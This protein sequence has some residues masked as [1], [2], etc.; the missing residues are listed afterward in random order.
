MIPSQLPKWFARGFEWF[1]K[2][3]LFDELQGDLEEAFQEN[4]KTYGAAKARNIYRLE[5]LKM[6][7]PS[8]VGFG[9]FHSKFN[10]LIMFKNYF[11]T[12]M[13]SMMKSPLSS[14]INIFGLSVA[15]GI[16]LI[17][18]AF[19]DQDISIDQF[20]E[21]KHQVYLVTAFADRDGEVLQYGQSPLP[22]ATHMISDLPQIKKSS[23]VQDINT[24]VKYE[25]RVFHERIRL[26]DPDFLDMLTFPMQWGSPETLNDP[27]SI[28]LSND[29]AIKY[30]G[31]LNPVG[32][33]LLINFGNDKTKSFAISGV[34][35]PFPNAHAIDFDFLINF[36]NIEQATEN[37]DEDNWDQLIAATLIQINQVADLD[38]V[39][40]QL[41]RYRKLQNESNPKKIIKSVSLV[42][43]ADLHMVS[44][45]IQNGISY[46]VRKEGWV[47][48]SIMAGFVMLL[49][50]MNYINIGIVSAAKRLKEI[51][52]RKVIGANRRLVLVQLLTENVLLTS[53][54]LLFG[55]FLAYSL[56]IPW[57]NSL[58]GRGLELVLTQPML[59]LFLG[60]MLLITGLGSGIY[61]ALYISKF[62]V[63]GIFRGSIQLGK[64]SLMTKVFLTFQ[65]VLA[66]I[67]IS[68]GV[69][70]TQNNA[71]QA[72][73]SW[74][75]SAD[76][77][78]YVDVPDRSAFEQMH[79]AM[80]QNP[81]VISISG[82]SQHMGHRVPQITI[83]RP[84][85][86]FT[87]GMMRVGSNYFRTMGI[88]LI[89]GRTFEPHSEG[90]KQM[91]VVNEEFAKNL[92]LD[93]PIGEV[94][95]VDSLR[96][97]II[98]VVKDFHN[99]DF[100]HAIQPIIF[101]L[102]DK[103]AFR[104]LSVKVND[105]KQPE[106]YQAFR[107]AWMAHLPNTPFRGGYQSGVFNG[108]FEYLDSSAEFM[109]ALAF[110][111]ILLASLGLYGLI[112][113]NVSGRNKEFSIRKILG[114]RLSHI[115]KI[116]S[117]QYVPLFT[118]SMLLGA[119]L[120][121]WLIQ[122][123]FDTVFAYHMPMN[124]TGL[125]ISGVFLVAV[126]GIV[127]WVQVR[128]LAKANA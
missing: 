124:Y 105:G 36:D 30:F 80:S 38:L 31:D 42:S 24:V 19:I 22:L 45:D 120:G 106:V 12:S 1:C 123:L 28:I 69:W 119:P 88:D 112:T 47:I 57:F 15:I 23:R 26:V 74:G 43:L 100:D 126:L 99:R 35:E 2:A 29:M 39:I 68:G 9:Q 128:K 92:L 102:T 77:V 93:D 71:Y 79:A 50:C 115:A 95:K 5:V 32:K 125:I 10:H 86:D 37:Y 67:T 89:H 52:V 110:V 16:C 101:N 114:A 73:R 116:I 62:Q 41:D 14:F 7:R 4:T 96:L 17:V 8:V 27:T 56:F 60:S 66:F 70:F 107:E 117:T 51:G 18:Y 21:N 83:S 75:Y 54:A 82:S 6:L 20:H 76:K 64:K 3:E 103:D 97:E 63:V 91:I 49:A 81:D 87:V 44:N 104:F 72:N 25:D 109:R 13:R 40:D 48:L 98:G 11:K 121:Y 59:W 122:K 111:S 61:P 46:G 55:L 53:F 108:Y 118:I 58:F 65:L 113:L 94:I 84:D 34:A 33:D 78:L 90:D 85:R 127:T